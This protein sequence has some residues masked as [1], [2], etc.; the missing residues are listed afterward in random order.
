MSDEAAAMIMHLGSSIT[1]PAPGVRGKIAENTLTVS[2]SARWPVR[3]L[4]P[5][6]CEQR[7]AAPV[8]SRSTISNDRAL[9]LVIC[10][11]VRLAGSL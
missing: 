5:V 2:D 3:G 11:G 7:P 10:G 4:P 9:R 6:R 8:T 1:V